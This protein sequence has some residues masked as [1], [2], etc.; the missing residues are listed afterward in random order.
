MISIW[1]LIYELD[2]WLHIGTGD[3]IVNCPDN[4]PEYQHL[5]SMMKRTDTPH[6]NIPGLVL[7]ALKKE[8]ELPFWKQPTLRHLIK[9]QLRRLM[10][11]G[12]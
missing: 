8:T 1:K 12:R 5:V 9:L 4:R 11:W 10:P 6:E 7:I 2:Y 3:D